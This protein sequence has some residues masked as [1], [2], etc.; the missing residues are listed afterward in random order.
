[1]LLTDISL[2]NNFSFL[3]YLLC[4]YLAHCEQNVGPAIKGVIWVCV[5]ASSHTVSA[6]PYALLR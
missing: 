1:M 6:E 4:H 3:L 5:T 2:Q